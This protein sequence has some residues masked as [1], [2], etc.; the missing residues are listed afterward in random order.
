MKQIN[1]SEFSKLSEEWTSI[2]AEYDGEFQDFLDNPEA[3][4]SENLG[5]ITKEQFQEIAIEWAN[6]DTE[7]D[8]F[9]Q[10]FLNNPLA[11]T[12]KQLAQFKNMQGRIYPLED[13]IYK[14]AERFFS[15]QEIQKLKAKQKRLFDIELE[16]YQV[17]EGTMIIQD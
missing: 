14:V 16:L 7:Y 15:A 13:E 11:H 4:T 10:A 17:A 12:P 8:N 1:K 3:M 2:D 9:F 5:L 6:I